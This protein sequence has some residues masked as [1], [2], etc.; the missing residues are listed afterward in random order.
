MK[1]SE[2]ARDMAQH[3]KTDASPWIFDLKKK[4]TKKKIFLPDLD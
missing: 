1:E 4:K 2:R 3:T